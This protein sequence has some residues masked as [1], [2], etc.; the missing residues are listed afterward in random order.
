MSPEDEALADF[1][2]LKR[3]EAIREKVGKM[4]AEWKARYR[5]FMHRAAELEAYSRGEGPKPK[6]MFIDGP[7]RKRCSPRST[8]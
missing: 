6:G 3:G 8:R 4:P 1:L 5:E 2:G 7:R